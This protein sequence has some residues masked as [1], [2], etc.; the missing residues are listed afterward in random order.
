MQAMYATR[1]KI[2]AQGRKGLMLGKEVYQPSDPLRLTP[3]SASS[4]L[5]VI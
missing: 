3:E 4:Y 5:V 1:S 2:K